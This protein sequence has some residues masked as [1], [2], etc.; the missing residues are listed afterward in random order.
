MDQMR[1]EAPKSL[2]AAVALLKGEEGEA[3]VLAGGTD[4][5]VLLHCDIIEPDLV[6]DIKHIPETMAI[7]ESDG[8]W[9]VGAAMPAMEIVD[10]EAFSKA[11]PGVIDGVKLIG[12]IQIK[13]R[14]SIGG[15]LCNASPAADGVPPLIVAGAVATVIG[16]GGTR[17]IAVED[18]VTGPRETSLARDEIIV[19]FTFPKRPPHSGDA[20]QRFTPRTEMDIA[21]VGVSVNVTLDDDGVCTAARVSL[22]AVAPTPLLVADAAAA[23]IG[24]TGDGAA[25]AKMAEAARAACNPIND[26]RGTVEYRIKVTGVLAERVARDAFERARQN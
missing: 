16:P 23:L 10:N 26:K 9:T 12:S 8:V 22:C 13:G 20:Y 25:L 19:S 14:A 11:W 3:C 6:V 1:Y 4:V 2:D 7:S 15:N 17:E 24:S 21:V 18:V 5:L